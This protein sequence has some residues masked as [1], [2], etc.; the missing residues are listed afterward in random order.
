MAGLK[1]LNDDASV[2]AIT[3]DGIDF[4]DVQG[5]VFDTRSD[6]LLVLD[7]GLDAIYRV[8][9]VLGEATLM[10]DQLGLAVT[11][12]GGINIADD[13]TTQRIVV[14]ATG[15]DRVFVFSITPPCSSADLAG[16]FG[17]LNFFDV[18]AFLSAYTALDP[19]A[20]FNDDGLFNF[21]DVSGF[22]SAYSMGCP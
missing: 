17:E 10:F 18:S 1:R 14:S 22:L 13:G 3:I 6:D 20:D 16:P 19:V 11:N 7:T 12:W 21:F 2:S 4:S 9:L 5:V 15:D 8:D